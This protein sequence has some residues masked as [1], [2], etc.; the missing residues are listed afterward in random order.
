MDLARA[1][2]ASR[3]GNIDDHSLARKAFVE[4]FQQQAGG[5]VGASAGTEGHNELHGF[6]GIVGCRNRDAQRQNQTEYGQ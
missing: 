3:S 2:R 6:V 4:C 1:H 5:H